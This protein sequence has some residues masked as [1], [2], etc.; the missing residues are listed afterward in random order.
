MAISNAKKYNFMLQKMGLLSRSGIFFNNSW[1]KEC[2]Q[3]FHVTSSFQQQQIVLTKDRYP[4]VKRGNYNNLN[5]QHVKYFQQILGNSRVLT[6]P[7][8]VQPYNVDWIKMVCG[9]LN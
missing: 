4:H 6:N 7:E 8:D 5:K 2:K 9:K 3:C 1:F